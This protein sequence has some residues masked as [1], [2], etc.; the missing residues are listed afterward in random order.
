[1]PASTILAPSALPTK[2]LAPAAGLTIAA[3]TCLLEG[4]AFDA[5]GNLYFS[6]II[7]NRMYRMAPEGI[8]SIFREDSGART[9]ATPSMPTGG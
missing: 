8:L 7:G 4:P 3:R 6:D 9:T 2:L 5:D 1:M